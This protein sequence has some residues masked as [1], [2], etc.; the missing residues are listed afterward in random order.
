MQQYA[1]FIVISVA[2][3]LVLVIVGTALVVVVLAAVLIVVI[4]GILALLALLGLMALGVAVAVIILTTLR[5]GRHGG[6]GLRCVVKLAANVN[7][8]AWR[9]AGQA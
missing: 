9:S 6:G 2:V 8:N 4:I 5:M 3:T 7:R 1:R